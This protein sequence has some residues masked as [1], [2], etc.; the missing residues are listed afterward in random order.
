VREVR[1]LVAGELLDGLGGDACLDRLLLVRVP[2]VLRIEVADRDQQRQLA[3]PLVDRGVKP[4]VRAERVDL[5]G[6]FRG[7]EPD[8]ERAAGGAALGRDL[9]ADLL[10]ARGELGWRAAG[11]ER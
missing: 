9:V 11:A 2:G 7:T 6:Q 1:H 10:L 8:E 3:E 4:A 5:L